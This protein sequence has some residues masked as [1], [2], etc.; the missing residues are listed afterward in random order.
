MYDL[1]TEGDSKLT[2]LGEFESL[3]IPC[4]ME[5]EDREDIKNLVSQ[6]YGLYRE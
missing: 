6:R 2:T 5:L 1:S 4:A 3:P